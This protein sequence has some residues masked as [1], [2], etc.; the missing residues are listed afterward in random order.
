MH[1]TDH[2]YFLCITFMRANPEIPGLSDSEI[3]DS[4]E[5]VNLN[6][7]CTSRLFGGLL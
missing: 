6:H 7:Y 4:K 3:H 2:I 1:V 5:R